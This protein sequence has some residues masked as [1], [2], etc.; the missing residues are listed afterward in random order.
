RA[1]VC[2]L[3]DKP[4]FRAALIRVAEDQYRLV[5]TIHHIVADGWSLP[6]L[7]R[8]VFGSYY[9]ERLPAAP[10][11]RSFVSWLDRQDRNAAQAVWRDV[12]AG[13]DAPTL[14]GTPGQ[15]GRHDVASFRM[16]AETTASLTELARLCH[17]TVST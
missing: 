1:A 2:G 6:I 11:Y 16:S 14:V 4:T 15:V 10:S 8:E 17:T 7:M 13:F 3:A 12:M 9:G 5:L